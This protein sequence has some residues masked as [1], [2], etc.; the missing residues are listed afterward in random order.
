MGG[1]ESRDLYSHYRC[2]CI[3]RDHQGFKFAAGDILAGLRLG[4]SFHVGWCVDGDRLGA[5]WM[6]FLR[7]SDWPNVEVLHR[8]F[9]RDRH[10]R[11][12]L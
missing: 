4:V 11:G 8:R 12:D 10:L 3:S 2:F 7:N 9:E 5:Y 6:A 1:D